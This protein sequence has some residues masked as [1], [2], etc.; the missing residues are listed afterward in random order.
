M[1]INKTASIF[2]TLLVFLTTNTLPVLLGSANAI[3]EWQNRVDPGLLKTAPSG[4]T[5]FLI[6]LDEQADLSGAAALTTQAAKGRF[7]VDTLRQTAQRTQAPVLRRLEAAGIPHRAYWISN[8]IWVRGDAH[9]LQELASLPEVAHIYANPWVQIDILPVEPASEL[10]KPAGTT[11]VEW[12][13]EKVN[14]DDVWAAGFTGQNVVVGGQDTGY[15]WDHPALINQ[16]RGWDG[17]TAV[18]DYNWHDAIHADIPESGGANACGFNSAV[19]CDDHGHGTHTMGTMVGDDGAGNQIGMAPGARWIGCRNMENGWGSPQSYIE[20]YQWF[21]APTDLNNENP[22]PD[23]APQVI[24]NSWSCP[25]EEGC[26][27]PLIL[28][29]VVQNVRAA[30]ILT[31][32]SAGNSGPACGSVDTPGAIYSKSFTVG[33]TLSNDT[34]NPSSSRGPVL[35]DGSGRMKPDISAPG[36]NIRSSY[37]NNSYTNLSGTSMAG[38]HVAGLVALLISAHPWLSGQVDLVE[39]IIQESAVPLVAASECGEDIPGVSIPNNTFGW[40]RIDALQ[41]YEYYRL[42]VTANTST[43]VIAPGWVLTYTLTVTN[44]GAADLSAVRL[45]NELP[46]G[47]TFVSASAGG[48][49]DGNHVVWDFGILA[50]QEIRQ[51][52]FNILPELPGTINNGNFFATSDQVASVNGPPVIVLVASTMIYQPLIPYLTP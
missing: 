13:I 10:E 18:H 40:G 4:E 32:H 28:Q 14:A 7:V 1:R 16:Y 30:G 26:T 39:T 25:P 17:S 29:T 15:Q 37:R 27:D 41:A 9:L 21:V 24:N 38:P 47:A 43:P 50:Q 11:A 3:P 2:F 5:E 48:Y 51:V 31:V 22:R 19:P 36:S 49:Q 45:F 34:I 52:E 8:L 35:V 6:S 46:A 23:L 20:C 33:N 42:E 12:N 44:S